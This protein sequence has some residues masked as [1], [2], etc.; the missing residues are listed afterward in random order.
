M[1]QGEDSELDRVIIR[2]IILVVDTADKKMEEE[3]ANG[4]EYV[5]KFIEE[6]CDESISDKIDE[7][8]E[9][10]ADNERLMKVINI[11]KQKIDI[12]RETAEFEGI[13]IEKNNKWLLLFYSNKN[14]FV[15]ST[16]TIH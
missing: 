5:N 8:E 14:L 12:Y 4:H 2:C 11:L 6:I 7:L 15:R 9:I 3:N 1:L 16:S 13:W 10:Y